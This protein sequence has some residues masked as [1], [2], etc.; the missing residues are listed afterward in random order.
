MP[1]WI[2]PA[3]AQAAATVVPLAVMLVRNDAKTQSR[4]DHVERSVGDLITEQKE[5]RAG[6]DKIWAALGRHDTRISVVESKIKE[7]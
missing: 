1:E 4:L 2:L 6:R 3:L 7:S 5:Q